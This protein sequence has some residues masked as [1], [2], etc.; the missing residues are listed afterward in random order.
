MSALIPDVC[1]IL[2]CSRLYVS[3]SFVLVHANVSLLVRLCVGVC[4]CVSVS[5]F[6][7]CLWSIC[8]REGNVDFNDNFML[9]AGLVL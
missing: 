2:S 8:M 5:L 1:D 9:G 4:V 7:C 6:F 3:A